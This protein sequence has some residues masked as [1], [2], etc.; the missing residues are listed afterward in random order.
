M[1]DYLLGIV[2]DRGC[3]LW[4]S[5]VTVMGKDGSHR[6]E[7]TQL[8]TVTRLGL[9]SWCGAR[10][11][12]RGCVSDYKELRLPLWFGDILIKMPQV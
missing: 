2:P 6:P 8:G 7:T 5:T 1:M 12:A 9:S 3:V 11:R 4:P 10:D